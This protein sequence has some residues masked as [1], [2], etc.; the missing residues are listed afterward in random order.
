MG[1]DDLRD[2]MY[3][4]GFSRLVIVYSRKGNPNKILFLNPDVKKFNILM[5]LEIKSLILQLDRRVRFIV[6]ELEL[7]YNGGDKEIY[8]ALTEFIGK[9]VYDPTR[10]D[11]IPAKMVLSPTD[12]EYTML[13]FVDSRGRELYPRIIVRR[14]K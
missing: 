6:N 8:D 4:K 13:K 5:E 11:G 12:D 2:L 1:L 7:V 3:R 10:I 9:Y 14:M